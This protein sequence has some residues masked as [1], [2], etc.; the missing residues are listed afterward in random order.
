VKRLF[1]SFRH[2]FRGL[3]VAYKTQPNFRLH[4]LA[5]VVALAL[6]VFIRISLGEWAALIIVIALVLGAELFNTALEFLADRITT[7]QDPLIGKAKDI[8]AAAVLVLALAAA[9]T[10][11]L[12]FLPKLIPVL[13]T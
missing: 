7:D 13:T 3:S 6:G 9:L 4:L 5:T 2:A 1:H 8:S 12:I 10:G 11:A